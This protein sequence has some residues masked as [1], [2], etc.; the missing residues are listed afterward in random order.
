MWLGGN[1]F[2]YCK[3]R[4]TVTITDKGRFFHAE[5]TLKREDFFLSFFVAL[6]RT[7]IAIGF[8]SKNFFIAYCRLIKKRAV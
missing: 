8:K 3:L 1:R 4:D 2:F 6:L 7:K 5:T